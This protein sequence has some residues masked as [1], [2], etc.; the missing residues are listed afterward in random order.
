MIEL[1]EQQALLRF[2]LLPLAQ[3]NQHI[4][5]TGDL[6]RSIEQRRWERDEGNTRAVRPLGNRFDTADR[7]AL[8][9]R[10]RHRTLIMRERR[11]VRKIKLPGHAPFVVAQKWCSASEVD[12]GLVEI[13]NLA[14]GVGGVDG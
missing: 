14:G 7:T 2:G 9:Q 5:G 6:A 10:D 8:L 1:V 3:I 11:A 12:G 4:D 13:G